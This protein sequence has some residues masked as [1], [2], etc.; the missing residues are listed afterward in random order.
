MTLYWNHT[1]PLL[2]YAN[3][4]LTIADLNPQMET[5]WAISRLEMLKLGWRCLLASMRR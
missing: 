3:G 1:G 5:R 2:R 4:A